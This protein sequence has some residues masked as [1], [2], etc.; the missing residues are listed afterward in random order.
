VKEVRIAKLLRIRVAARSAKEA[1][2]AVWKMCNELRIFN[3]A[4]HVCTV[5]TGSG[6]E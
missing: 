1:E 3:P 5:S 2:H 4:A 6:A